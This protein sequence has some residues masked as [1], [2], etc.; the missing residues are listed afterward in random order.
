MHY[1][2]LTSVHIQGNQA[3]RKPLSTWLPWKFIHNFQQSQAVWTHATWLSYCGAIEFDGIYRVNPWQSNHQFDT[4]SWR[5]SIWGVNIVGTHQ[6]RENHIICLCYSWNKNVTEISSTRISPI[7]FIYY[8]LLVSI[9][10]SRVINLYSQS[11]ND[12]PRNKCS[13]KI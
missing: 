3:N 5:T 8:R 11:N 10:Y 13:H 4:H 9:I 2:G 7:V 6:V 1:I 12:I